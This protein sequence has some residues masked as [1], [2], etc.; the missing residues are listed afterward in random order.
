MIRS[1]GRLVG[2]NEARRKVLDDMGFVWSVRSRETAS[3]GISYDQ[4]YEAIT[5]YKQTYP[6]ESDFVV[7]PSNFVVPDCDPWPVSTRGLPLGKKL[8]TMRTAGFLK[9]NPKVR[10]KLKELGI[11]T[12]MRAAVNDTRFQR[13]YDAL[14]RYKEI[15]GD[16]L[17]PQPFS[18]PEDSEEWPENTRGLRLGA[19]VNAIRSQGTFV[20]TNPERREML[21]EIGFVWSPPPAQRGRK[22]A[23]Q[24]TA[25]G[26]SLSP[27]EIAAS[28][29]PT[30]SAMEDLFGPSAD[31]KE[32]KP[33]NFDSASAL[34]WGLASSIE[35]ADEPQPSPRMPAKREYV[36][37]KSF[38]ESLNEAREMAI[39]VGILETVPY[40]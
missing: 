18:V 25:Q 3:S 20:N 19:R 2:A 4:I 17:V 34:E 21:N 16:L 40:V 29:T 10:G 35:N 36:P 13:V 27:A 15:Y 32:V 38:Q 8:G 31:F 14:K 24:G 22:K 5:A 33:F 11:E 28:I 6:Q 26:G 1:E 7:I 9:A 12:S 23:D 30:E 37:P 39:S